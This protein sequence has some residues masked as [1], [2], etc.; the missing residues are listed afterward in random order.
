MC[1]TAMSA[2]PM[3]AD[4][5]SALM[6]VRFGPKADN[7][8]HLFQKE[9]GPPLTHCKMC[10]RYLIFIDCGSGV[11]LISA[12]KCNQVRA[13]CLVTCAIFWRSLQNAS[14]RRTLVLCPA[15]TTER[16]TID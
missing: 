14:S 12:I 4:I 2:L 9:R 1:D 16:L 10:V 6:H 13:C 3:K 7:G 8:P 5:C 11:R 15:M